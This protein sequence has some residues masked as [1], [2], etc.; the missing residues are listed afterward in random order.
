MSSYRYPKFFG[1]V[2]TGIALFLAAIALLA[3]VVLD[4]LGAFAIG[5][6]VG[7]LLL[8]ESVVIWW[9]LG[10]LM[11]V[12]VRMEHDVLV[13]RSA[14]REIRIP[15]RSISQLRF[16]LIPYTAG[17]IKIVAGPNDVRLTVALLGIHAFVLELRSGLLRNA[18]IS[19]EDE[20]RL[21]RFFKTAAFSDQS[22]ERAG[23]VFWKAIGLV[24]LSFPVAAMVATAARVDADNLV[25]MMIPGPLI[26][27]FG[28]VACE[29][30]FANRLANSARQEIYT[31][32]PRDKA[33]EAATFREAIFI[34]TCA[35][36]L[37]LA[38][39]LATVA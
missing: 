21:F 6:A 1:P 25:V 35:H 27:A 31:V 33:F 30:V 16:P 28:L 10:R 29:A 19:R 17:W 32:A 15:Y 7:A 24:L 8:V 20:E 38:L 3:V 13:Y 2:R 5:L 23:D 22:R 36:I 11:K 14:K 4:K 37:A 9:T 12:E 39:A 26:V 34:G 18:A